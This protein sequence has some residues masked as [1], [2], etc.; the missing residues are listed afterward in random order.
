MAYR[1]KIVKCRLHTGGKSIDELRERYKGQGL[2]YRDL[3]SVKRSMDLFDGITLFLS[4]WDYDGGVDYHVHSWG[5]DVDEKMMLATYEA[6]QTHPFP[7]YKD[8]REAFIAD[9]KAGNYDPGCPFVFWP[10]DVE[11]L[12]IVQEEQKEDSGTDGKAEE[13]APPR[14]RKKARRR[15]KH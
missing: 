1:P 15:K 11:E 12:E 6:E 9:W 10:A 2:T 7:Q 4:L 14:Q 5:D 3:E 8:R 13:K